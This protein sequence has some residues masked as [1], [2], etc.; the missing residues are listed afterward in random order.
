MFYIILEYTVLKKYMYILQNIVAKHI[1][2]D[3]ISFYGTTAIQNNLNKKSDRQKSY[4][5]KDHKLQIDTRR[6]P[7]TF[8]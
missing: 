8:P 5:V 7:T 1:L 3:K 2:F 4:S 6:H